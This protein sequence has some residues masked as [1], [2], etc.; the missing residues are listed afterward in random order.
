MTIN[1]NGRTILR[2]TA[3]TIGVGAAAFFGGQTT[4]MSDDAIASQKTIAVDTAVKQADE[5]HAAEVVEL[6]ADLRAEKRAAVNS[7]VK[8]TVK[9]ER[10]RAEKLADTAR[11]EGYASGNTA[12]YGAGHSS[13]PHRGLRRGRRR[14]LR[15]RP[16]RRGHG[17]PD[18]LR[19]PG[20]HRS[21]LLLGRRRSPNDA[22]DAEARQRAGLSLVCPPDRPEPRVGSHGIADQARPARVRRHRGARHEAAVHLLQHARR[23]DRC[24]PPARPARPGLR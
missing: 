9:N 12:G 22:Q 15:R 23:A 14:R 20:S 3:A 8:R 6:T 2:V 7:A 18:L 4:R 1:I 21:S 24:P 17:L 10:K 11:D 5:E 13:G 16:G 19:R